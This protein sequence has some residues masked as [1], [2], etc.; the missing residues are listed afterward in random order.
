MELELPR[1]LAPDLPSNRYSLMG[2]GIIHYNLHSRRAS[3][4][5]IFRRC[6]TKAGIGQFARLLPILTVVAVSQAP[7][8]ESNP[9]SPLP[10]TAMVVHYTTIQADRAECRP[11]SR[12]RGAVRFR[13]GLAW[14]VKSAAL[15]GRWTFV[16]AN[17]SLAPP[18]RFPLG[19][20]AEL[21]IL[22]HVL[23]LRLEGL[24]VWQ[25]E[26]SPLARVDS[27]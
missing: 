20:V 4:V 14:V 2:L 9:H 21:R 13:A 19:A 6:L 26:R 11:R 15:S 12:R 3:R 27:R 7:S 17:C 24:S 10:V 16:S 5:V 8:P 1:L 23:A 22:V 25:G 18:L